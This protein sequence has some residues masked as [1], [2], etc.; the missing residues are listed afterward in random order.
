MKDRKIV[1]LY[2]CCIG[3]TIMDAINKMTQTDLPNLL[4][5][6]KANAKTLTTLKYL[7]DIGTFSY[8][9]PTT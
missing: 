5:I 1:D 7:K 9:Y 6:K 3:L 2:D 4:V 8:T